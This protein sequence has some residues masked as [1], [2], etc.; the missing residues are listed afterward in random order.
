MA[1]GLVI[2]VEAGEAKLTE[3]LTQDRIR[4]GAGDDC[5]LRLPRSVVPSPKGKILELARANGH[6]RI[7]DF[8]PDLDITHN[9][10]PLTSDSLINDGDEV[11]IGGAALTL[12]FFS[13]RSLPPALIA[14]RRDVHVAPFIE[15]AALEAAATERRD[16]AKV[17]LREFTRELIREISPVTKLFILTTTVALVGGLL[18][19]G[20][21]A[22]RELRNSR[23]LINDQQARLFELQQQLEQNSQQLTQVERSNRALLSSQSL[24][25]K[26][27]SDYSAG[28]CMIYGVYVLVDPSSN[29]PLRATEY[30]G[31]ENVNGQPF[32]S[33]DGG[34]SVAEFWFTGTGFHVGGGYVLTNRHVVQPWSS[35][36]RLTGLQGNTAGRP[37]LVKLLAF[38]PRRSQPIALRVRQVGQREDIAVCK[39]EEVPANLPALPLDLEFDSVAVGR[40]VVMIGY[41]SGPDRILAALPEPEASSIRARYTSLDA[42]LLHLAS[43]NLITPLTTQGSITDLSVRRIAYDARTAEGGSGAP[44]FGPSGKVIGINFAIFTENAASN[45]AIPIRYAVPLLE[46]AGWSAPQAPADGEPL[47]KDRG[48]R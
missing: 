31:E 10:A 20:F 47:T 36:E 39:L 35:D 7:A 5:E 14:D 33:P 18:Y 34:G 21:A 6:Y 37:R 48:V 2:H 41:P 12:Q 16:D 40:P 3:I 15:Q 30:R 24:A 44:V 43:R 45:F 17:F 11:R 38:F 27:W 19:L 25:T 4:I 32:L 42:L 29:R 1:S 13:I 9:G 46:R 8:D 23:R 22:Y 28:V 26:V